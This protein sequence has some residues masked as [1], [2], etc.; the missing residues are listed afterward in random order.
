MA[1]RDGERVSLVL[2]WDLGQREQNPNHVLNLGFFGSTASNHREL[3][4]LG[5]VLVDADAALE[6]GAEDG[7]ARL[8]DL[9]RGRGIA[10][11]DELLDRHLMRPVLG[12]EG[13]NLIEDE[14]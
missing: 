2:A 6:P 11:E 14:P 10:R 4:R 8:A 12:H 9:E 5:A 7:A 13:G 3:D 1:E